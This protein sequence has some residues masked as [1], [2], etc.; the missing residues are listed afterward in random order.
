[1]EGSLARTVRA[2]MGKI[3]HTVRHTPVVPPDDE[4]RLRL[5]LIAE[6]FFELLDATFKDNSAPD[7]YGDIYQARG[8][9]ERAIATCM[10]DVS[11][12]DFTDALADI[13][14]VVEGSRASF[15]IDGAP[16]AAAVHG[17]NMAKLAGGVLREDGKFLKPAGW[18]PPDIRGTLAAQ[19]WKAPVLP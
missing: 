18:K 15:G 1:V 3:G 5:R 19:G 10:V 13:D 16:V 11:L 4:V 17:A 7:D 6:E 2:F 8:L 12:V 9:V 14:Y